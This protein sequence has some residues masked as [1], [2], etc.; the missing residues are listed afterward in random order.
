M[1]HG[2][3]NI[4]SLFI[5]HSWGIGCAGQVKMVTYEK[6]ILLWVVLRK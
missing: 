4:K 5:Q 6:A 2:T 3:I 1:M